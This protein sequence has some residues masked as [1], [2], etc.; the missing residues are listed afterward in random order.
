MG[1]GELSYLNYGYEAAGAFKTPVTADKVFGEDVK[2]RTLDKKNNLK[3]IFQLGSRNAQKLI[4]QAYEGVLG[5]DFYLTNPWFLTGVLGSNSVTGSG[6]YTHTFSEA[7]LPPSLTIENG[8]DLDSDAVMKYLGACIGECRISAAVG[9]EPTKVSLTIPYATETKATSGIGSQVATVEEVHPYAHADFEYPAG[10]SIANTDNV[11]LVINNSL[12]MV[13][14]LGSRLA[15][16]YSM[17][18]R[19]YDITTTNFFDDATAY[20]EKLYGAATGPQSAVSEQADCK[21]VFDNGLASTEQRKFTYTFTGAKIGSHSLPQRVE[22]DLMEN[23][24]IT[25]RDLSIEVI[26]NTAT[27]P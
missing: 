10:T 22:E 11:E 16:R 23:V 20:L 13:N 12:K 4:E 9:D 2:I 26:N 21:I 8:I 5:I 24:S 6:P 25:C 18:Q 1:G 3:R 19:M 14:A 27:M 7:N 15:S 17:R